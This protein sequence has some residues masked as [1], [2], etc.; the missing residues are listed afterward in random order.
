MTA[1]TMPELP[2]P[3]IQCCFH[4]C[5]NSA[6]VR[7]WTKTGWVNVCARVDRSDTETIYHYEKVERAPRITHNL[8]MDDLRAAYRKSAAFSGAQDRS[9]GRYI[10]IV[11]REPGE[12]DEG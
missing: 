6:N 7:I 2:R 11:K 5:P 4:G 1:P 9:V 12:D 8:V 10:P 3:H